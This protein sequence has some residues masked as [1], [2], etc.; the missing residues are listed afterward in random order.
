MSVVFGLL[1]LDAVL[2]IVAQDRASCR[3]VERVTVAADLNAL[4]VASG[5]L[6]GSIGTATAMVPWDVIAERV[7]PGA[8]AGGP[9]SLRGENGQV[10]LEA[11][12][13]GVPAT[14]TL[15]PEVTGAG[16]VVLSPTGLSIAGR[17]VPLAAARSLGLAD[18]LAESRA[19]QGTQGLGLDYDVTSVSVTEGGLELGV[20][21]P[22]SALT[23][24]G[25]SPACPAACRKRLRACS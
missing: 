10:V 23:P 24:S 25:S 11:S 20:R 2:G 7:V 12:F 21:L 8:A 5:V 16:E 14:V 22:L 6:T 15:L 18:A 4:P 1:A 9:V 17:E 13:R 19:L 3:V